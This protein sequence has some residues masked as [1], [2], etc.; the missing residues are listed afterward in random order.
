MGI[1]PTALLGLAIALI[2]VSALPGEAFNSLPCGSLH[3]KLT[4]EAA[5]SFGF[6]RQG[7][8]LLVEGNHL[9][10]WGQ[11]SFNLLPG[12]AWLV[13]NEHYR[14]GDHFDRVSV[15]E[16]HSAAFVR[17]IEALAGFRAG[18]VRSIAAGELGPGLRLIGR[19]SHGLQD[20]FSHSNFVDLTGVE[21]DRVLGVLAGRAPASAAPAALKLTG[22]HPATGRDLPGDDFGHDAYAKDAP[23]GNE[24]A[25]KRLGAKTKHRLAYEAARAATRT[26]LEVVR[27]RVGPARWAEATAWR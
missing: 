22:Y 25:E 20:F 6:T 26:L 10:D 21:Q 5:R 24:E 23:G 19:A 8:A 2:G 7:V 4:Q 11:V 27:A 3:A 17:G 13:P 12:K 14:P 18:A 1:P 9:Q 16:G 15:E